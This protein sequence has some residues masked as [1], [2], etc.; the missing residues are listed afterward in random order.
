[1]SL[2]VTDSGPPIVQPFT[3]FKNLLLNL[4]VHSVESF[5]NSVLKISLLNKLASTFY[6]H[7][8]VQWYSW[9]FLVSKYFVNNGS[10]SYDT[11]SS[12]SSKSG[13]EDNMLEIFMCHWWNVHFYIKFLNNPILCGKSYSN[14]SLQICRSHLKQTEIRR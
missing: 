1:M 9:L 14:L 2:K 7:K 12:S 13:I 10:T 5:T 6:E 3:C 4:N 11:S 8:F